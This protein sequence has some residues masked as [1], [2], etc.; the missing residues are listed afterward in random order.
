MEQHLKKATF[1]VSDSMKLMKFDKVCMYVHIVSQSE[2]NNRC[3]FLP[4]PFG[5]LGLV[6]ALLMAEIVQKLGCKN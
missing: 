6:V 2:T 4:Q 5:L 1:W 3:C